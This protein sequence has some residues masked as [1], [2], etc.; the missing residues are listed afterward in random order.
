MRFLTSAGSISK[1][2]TLI[3]CTWCI[4][5]L[6][7]TFPATQAKAETF[8]FHNDQLGT[9]Q[10]VTDNNQ[11]VVWQGNYD[12]FG[13]CTETVNLIEQ[14][15]RFPGQYF[16]QET[17]LHYNYFRTY[18]PNTGR[19]LESDPI[20]LNG[21]I[22][23][24]GYANQNGLKYIDPTGEL[25]LIVLIPLVSGL[26]NGVIE[27]FEE[28]LNCDSNVSSIIGAF[29]RGFASGAG[30]SLAGIGAFALVKDVR[31]AGA[32]GSAVGTAIEQ[33]LTGDFSAGS[34]V[35]AAAI[36]AAA[37]PVARKVFPRGR[38]APPSLFKPRNLTNFGPNSHQLVGQEAA[39]SAVAGGVGT[40][41]SP[42]LR[43]KGCGC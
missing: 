12:P 15:I 32:A 37:G 31:T 26:V 42:N 20:G 19:Y 35:K 28:S 21:G 16:D 7:V 13:A 41:T 23:T 39:F 27:E 10:V 38:G 8:Y 18:D 25:P 4:G 2:K 29:A 9:P 30:G 40:A 33:A 3:M 34:F 17:G 36:G 5:L 43:D 24:Y 14:N 6:L 11:Q 22:S 1:S